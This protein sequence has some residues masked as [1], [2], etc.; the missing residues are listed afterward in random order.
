MDVRELFPG[1]LWHLGSRA[2]QSAIFKKNYIDSNF[3]SI[4]Q[5][6][7]IKS[8][9]R[10]LSFFLYIL[11]HSCSQSLPIFAKGRYIFFAI[12]FHWLKF[13]KD[14]LPALKKLSSL[15][16]VISIC[17]HLLTRRAQGS[18]QWEPDW[19]TWRQLYP[20]FHFSRVK[21]KNKSFY[22]LFNSWIEIICVH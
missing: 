15:L 9:N 16:F 4:F 10:Q 5:C 14:S 8:L 3:Y 19:Q 21:T 22:Q 1:A 11:C 20:L 17:W 2:L 13:V 12:Y 6:L 18:L 7:M